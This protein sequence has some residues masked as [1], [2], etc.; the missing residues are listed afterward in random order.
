MYM[1]KPRRP[2]LEAATTGAIIDAFRDV[3]GAFGFGDR[4]YIYSLALERDLIAKE[5]R[6]DR[7]VG[8]MVYYRG[9]RL[10]PQ[11]VESSVG[12]DRAEDRTNQFPFVPVQ[13]R[14]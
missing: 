7:E 5:C 4:E 2:L 3:H 14:S 8:L 13:T 12:R 11:T 1:D 6:V 10:A 9:E